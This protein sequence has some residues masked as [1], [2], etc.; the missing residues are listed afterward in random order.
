MR[1]GFVAASFLTASFLTTSLVLF[2][3]LGGAATA[4]AQG[5]AG[6]SPFAA[7]PVILVPGW[8]PPLL[9]SWR[10]FTGY[11]T[12]DGVDPA[13]VHVLDYDYLGSLEEIRTQLHDELQR[14][15]ARYDEGERFTFVTHSTGQIVALDLIL[16]EG[17]DARVASF[18]SLGGIGHGFDFLPAQVG[19]MGE[20]QKREFSP[21]LSPWIQDFWGA[22]GERVAAMDTCAVFSPIDGIVHPFDSGRMP[23]GRD[24]LV[25]AVP[26][27][28]LITFRRVYERVRRDCF[29][30]RGGD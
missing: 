28:Q 17:L 22:Y 18:V 13:R 10:T 7:H 2:A 16:R 3:T 29:A 20:A 8:G 11:L 26:H 25:H 4:R 1:I 27:L 21:Y 5:A 19:L 30:P 14:V 9:T 6:P 24:V 15:L 23:N 12:A